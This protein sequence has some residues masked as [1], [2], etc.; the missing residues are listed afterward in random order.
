MNHPLIIVRTG[1]DASDP[2]WLMGFTCGL[3]VWG[4]VIA[5]L[6]LRRVP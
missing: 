5:W 3:L 1:L 2:Y 6:F 4:F